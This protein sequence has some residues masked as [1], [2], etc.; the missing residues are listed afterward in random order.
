ML[1]LAGVEQEAG[2]IASAGQLFTLTFHYFTVLPLCPQCLVFVFGF[3]NAA[4]VRG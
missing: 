1:R 3:A 4:H 2:S